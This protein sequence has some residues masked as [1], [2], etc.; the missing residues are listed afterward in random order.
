M[1]LII[2]GIIPILISGQIL[3]TDLVDAVSSEGRL[4]KYLKEESVPYTGKVYNYYE[5]EIKLLGYDEQAKILLSENRLKNL[6]Y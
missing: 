5:Q 1:F 2:F 3:V 6:K 4:I